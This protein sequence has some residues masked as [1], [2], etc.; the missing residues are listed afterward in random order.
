MKKLK[1]YCQKLKDMNIFENKYFSFI[2]IFFFAVL[3]MWPTIRGSVRI[4]DDGLFHLANIKVIAD[5]LPFSIF[6]KILPDI[7]N[8]FG[9]GVGIFYPPLPHIVGAFIYKFVNIFGISVV[10]AEAILHFLI[11][12]AS[13]ITM[14]MLGKTVFKSNV[15]ALIASLFY[16]TYNYFFVDV[17]VRDALNESFMFI[18]MPLVF[19]GLFHL[20]NDYNIKKF[21][22]YFVIG[23]VGLMYSHLVMSVYFT[24]FLLVFLLFY[25]KDI[26]N[27]KNFG[28][29]CLAALMILVFTS[30]FTVPM[31][32]HKLSGIEYVSFI[33]RNWSINDVWSM[34]FKGFFV[35]YAYS[36]GLDNKGLIYSDLNFIVTI[37]FILALIRIFK[38]K[39]DKNLSKFLIA[40]ICF[41]F[42]GIILNAFKSVWLHVPSLLLSIQF[43]WRLSQFVGFAFALVAAEGLQSY[44]NMFK[45]KYITIALCIILVFLVSFVYANNKKTVF[46]YDVK[47]VDVSVDGAARE[48]FP[49]KLYDNIEEFWKKEYKINILK[50]NADVK[51]IEDD[52]PYMK[53][54]VKNIKDD[55][56]I[57]LPRIYYLGYEVTNEQDEIIEYDF[58]NPGYI[59]LNIIDNGVYELKYVGT[60]GYKI[61]VMLKVVMI[62]GILGFGLYKFIK[63]NTGGSHV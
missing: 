55:L 13:G 59:S 25:I 31:I 33:E 6:S 39:V 45:S 58:H 63:Y 32:E 27:K 54:E 19:L 48:H 3:L 16:I 61:A 62:F 24:L 34:P 57:E 29:L 41:G 20:F 51:I 35:N 30:T 26:F 2:I 7:A 1:L 23:Y 60:K 15:K 37:F 36:N 17:V 44:L 28:H 12:L 8:N 56:K 47:D 9:F 5:G 22:I 49:I 53:F 50:G 42:L 21:Y 52:S 11:F 14:Y 4:G 38:K 18:F 46:N 40:I 43:V 10:N